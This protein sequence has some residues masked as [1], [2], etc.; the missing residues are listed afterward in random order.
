VDAESRGDTRFMAE[1]VNYDR[2]D[3]SYTS[4]GDH[5]DNVNVVYIITVN[6]FTGVNGPNWN[7]DA[8]LGGG[9]DLTTIDF[10]EGSSNT[11]FFAEKYA[12]CRVDA[13]T[14][15]DS[16]TV[17]VAN[18]A[19]TDP[20]LPPP[21]ASV[22]INDAEQIDLRLVNV[23]VVDLDLTGSSSRTAYDVA[24]RFFDAD[25]Q[26]L[27]EGLASVLEIEVDSLGRRNSVLVSSK[28]YDDVDL[29]LDLAAEMNVVQIG[30]LLPAIQKVPS[31]ACVELDILG[32]TRL[33]MEVAEYDHV[34]TSYT[35]HGNHSDVVHYNPY[36]TVDSP[37]TTVSV[38][39]FKLGDGPNN[40]TLNAEGF[41]QAHTEV[42][43][44]DGPNVVEVAMVFPIVDGQIVLNGRPVSAHIDLGDGPNHLTYNATGY[45]QV[46]SEILLG[47][48]PNVVQIGMLLPAVQKVRESAARWNVETG[49]ET[50]FT[51]EVTGYDRVD[52]DLDLLGEVGGVWSSDASYETR[53]RNLRL[54]LEP[55]VTVLDDEAIDVLIG[56]GGRD[57]FFADLD[58][59]DNDDDLLLD[60]KLKEA[61]DLL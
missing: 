44:G 17:N 57:W 6:P 9:D 45:D 13:G 4:H 33:E 61:I 21:E 34:H 46:D 37:V 29:D 15:R 28:G 26:V 55:K 8:F 10:R 2:I 23:R 30:L 5:R 20:S 38:A 40:L 41:D 7:L 18:S 42:L 43:A 58:G 25:V 60:A 11:L 27:Y 51:A 24:G 39:D 56:S 32:D 14:G 22:E 3:T 53:V 12:T 31:A 59:L 36:I 35:S 54:W 49:G 1:I 47:N 52:L 50:A 16:V 19:A 48:G